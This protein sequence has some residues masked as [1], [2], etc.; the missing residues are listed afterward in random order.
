MHVQNAVKDSIQLILKCLYIVDLDFCVTYLRNT[1]FN[2]V[3]YLTATKNILVYPIN[4]SSNYTVMVSNTIQA[5]NTC[6]FWF[7]YNSKKVLY[8][9]PSS[10]VFGAGRAKIDISYIDTLHFKYM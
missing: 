6:I 4:C 3:I 2:S 5:G 9:K 7:I 8:F 1:K 10:K